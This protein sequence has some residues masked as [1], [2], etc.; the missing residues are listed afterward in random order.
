MI[1]QINEDH[2][3]AKIRMGNNCLFYMERSN[4]CRRG[5]EQASKGRMQSC[6]EAVGSLSWRSEFLLVSFKHF[7]WRYRQS[8]DHALRL[9][10]RYDIKFSLCCWLPVRLVSEYSKTRK[11]HRIMSFN[12]KPALHISFVKCIDPVFMLNTD[13]F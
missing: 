11:N 6:L 12:R 3:A 4:V 9:H 5:R 8:I 1:K 10:V 13:I 7:M 2:I